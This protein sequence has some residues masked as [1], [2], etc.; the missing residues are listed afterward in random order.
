MIIYFFL[1]NL[2]TK[3]YK[4]IIVAIEIISENDSERERDKD[5]VP[6]NISFVYPDTVINDLSRK[7]DE[8]EYS[9]V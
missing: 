1:S 6:R 8:D 7:P 5:I 2:F 3:L 9:L 4:I